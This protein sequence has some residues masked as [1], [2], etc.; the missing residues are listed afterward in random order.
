MQLVTAF[1]VTVLRDGTG[2]LLKTDAYDGKVDAVD[3][4]M[5]VQVAVFHNNLRMSKQMNNLYGLISYQNTRC[6]CTWISGNQTDR[7]L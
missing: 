3:G 1:A 5:Q 6:F 4:K 7:C 2:Q